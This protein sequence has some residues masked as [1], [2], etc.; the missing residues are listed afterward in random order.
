MITVKQLQPP[1]KLF[2][3]EFTLFLCVIITITLSA[4]EWQNG[5]NGC[6]STQPQD[7]ILQVHSTTQINMPAEILLPTDNTA[8]CQDDGQVTTLPANGSVSGEFPSL[9]YT[10]QANFSGTDTFSYQIQCDAAT[11]YQIQVDVIN[12]NTGDDAGNS[13]DNVSGDDSHNNTADNTGEMTDNDGNDSDGYTGEGDWLHT[14]GNRIVDGNGKT[15]WLTGANWFGFNAHERVFHGLWSVELETTLKA[16]AQRGINI[17]RVPISTELLAEWMT[18]QPPEPIGLNYYANPK[19]EGLNTLEIFDL[20]LNLCEKYGLK[21]MLDVHSAEAN[22]SG[23]VF[24][25]W[26][27]EGI[28]TETFYKTWEWVADR[29]KDNDTLIAFD[30]EN[31]PHGKVNERPRA[32]WDDTS[33]PDNW[34]YVFEQASKR[35]LARNPNVLVLCEGIEVYP[36][37]DVNWNDTNEKAFY[38]TWWGGNLRGVADYPVD[39]AGH[40]NQLVYSPHDYGPAVWPQAWFEGDFT[41]QSLYNDVWAP[42]WFFIQESNLAPLLIGEWGGFMDGGD[43]EKWMVL[44]RNF[45]QD[46]HIHHTFWCINPNSGD[47]GGLLDHDWITWDEVKYAL[48]KPVLWQNST[49]K[50][51][52][53]DH[54]IPLGGSGSTTGISLNQYY[55]NGGTPP[56]P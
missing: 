27:T 5:S 56:N 34:K 30:L 46:N 41:Q 35:I 22:N 9:M 49:G 55:N 8:N 17:L 28:S 1:P 4:C 19:L 40:Q 50:F 23:H 43:N 45:I 44:L 36:M 37:P 2:R 11:T 10:P 33:D 12:G 6:D 31:E 25:M 16:I 3:F 47:T 38:G 54:E 39:L 21:V 48:L 20:T 18:G 26:Y 14:R 51:V 42:N 15:V 32:K 52:G 7:Q 53:L 29:Y 24:P 13:G